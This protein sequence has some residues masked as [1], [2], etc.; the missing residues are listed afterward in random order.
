MCVHTMYV[1]VGACRGQKRALGSL[2]LEFQDYELPFGYWEVNAG[3]LAR[4]V[5]ALNPRARSAAS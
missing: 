4:A 3:S 5:S 2:G 1:H